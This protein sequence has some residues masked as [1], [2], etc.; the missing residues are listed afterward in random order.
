MSYR[1]GVGIPTRRIAATIA[2]ALLVCLWSTWAA[3]QV[4]IQPK[5]EIFGGYSWLGISGHADLGTKVQDINTGFDASS[6]YYFPFAHN[7][8]VIVDGSGHFATGA[9][10]Y[11]GIGFIFGGLQY[12]YHTN[13]FS[14]FVHIM[15][16]AANSFLRP[17]LQ[18]RRVRT[19]S[20]KPLSPWAAASI[21][22]STI[23][24]R[25]A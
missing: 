21:T 9:P 5:D 10:D 13:S 12:K 1:I 4:T 2:L 24:F 15:G 7:L 6:T 20:G 23:D 17:T 11:T 8:G 16:G 18:P 25:C 19:M 22:L 3:A 14:P